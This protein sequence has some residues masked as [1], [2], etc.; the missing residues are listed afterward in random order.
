ML[1]YYSCY[2]VLIACIDSV[3]EVARRELYQ[4]GFIKLNMIISKTSMGIA[5]KDHEKCFRD[6]P[7]LKGFYSFDNYCLVCGEKLTYEKEF[8]NHFCSDC[9]K[10]IYPEFVPHNF[11]PECGARFDLEVKL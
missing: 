4:R 9:G 2:L 10:Q 11:C 3:L 6:N 5:H 1:A 7:L 8:T